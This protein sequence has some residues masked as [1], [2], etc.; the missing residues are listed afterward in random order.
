MKKIS[1]N[2][3]NMNIIYNRY[4]PDKESGAWVATVKKGSAI[5]YGVGMSQEE[6]KKH[7]LEKTDKYI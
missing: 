2:V 7:L 5:L 3:G 6:A 1:E 4:P